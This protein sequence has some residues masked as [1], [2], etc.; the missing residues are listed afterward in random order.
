MTISIATSVDISALSSKLSSVVWQN[1]SAL[2]FSTINLT[3]R[4]QK[5]QLATQLE[6]VISRRAGKRASMNELDKLAV[7][8]A[9]HARGSLHI[10]RH[11]FILIR[12][13]KIIGYRLTSGLG[14]L[15]ISPPQS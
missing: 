11:F 4:R 5:V 12:V 15:I 6:L 13:Y 9:S 8:F 1:F 2:V 10:D 14:L 7:T 3:L